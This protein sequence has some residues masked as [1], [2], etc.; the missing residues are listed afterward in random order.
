MHSNV[1][2]AVRRPAELLS[3]PAVILSSLA[4]WLIATLGLRPLM[5]PDEGRYVGVARAMFSGDLLV[6]TLNG[7]PFFHKPPLFYWLDIAAMHVLGISEFAG[8]FGAAVGAWIMGA[9]FWF[10]M[11]RSH[12]ER[13]ATIG[14]GVLATTPFFFIGGQYANHDVLVA[15]LITA[16]VLAFARAVD[17][18]LRVDLRWLVAAWV[19]CALAL[20]SKGLIGFVLPALVIG[21]WLLMQGR[22]RQMLRLLHPLGLFAFALVAAP[23]CVAMQLR[24]PGFFDYFIVEQHFRRYAQSDFNNV[25][26]VWFFFVLLPLVT[27]PWSVWLPAALRRAWS[28]RDATVTL[29]A[30]WIVAVVG[31]FSIPS[32]KL[33]GYVLPALAPWCALIALAVDAPHTG[34]RPKPWRIVMGASALICVALVVV[35]AWK[36]PRSN[37]ELGLLLGQ[38]MAPADKVVMVQAYYYDVPFYARLDRPVVI[39]DDWS[40]P[41]I[42]K[43][44]NW[45]KEIF[46]AARFDPALGRELLQPLDNLAS[47]TCNA[48]TVWFVLPVTQEARVSGLPGAA[49][50]FAD[51]RTALWRVPG[52]RC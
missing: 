52:H 25:H 40:D 4:V 3:R 14:L 16:A 29:Y 1:A 42:P 37:R 38:R 17:D 47:Q 13:T 39:A 35:G 10:A 22:W 23:W 43:R 18:P 26:G 36:T 50:A 12:G 2:T 34:G 45:R 8:R 15:G 28:R 49:R 27:L 11:R 5:L 32:S 30:W 51:S 9:S 48:T 7:L 24:Y 33:L 41:E 6:P 46:D 44:D 21:P 31:F 19:G 20:L